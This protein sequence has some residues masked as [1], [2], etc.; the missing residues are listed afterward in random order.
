ML[1]SQAVRY[2]NK[3]IDNFMYSTTSPRAAA[4]DGESGAPPQ[5]AEANDGGRRATG[6][7]QS[8]TSGAG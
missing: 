6:G 1:V 3:S 2:K 8:P 5:P 4:A 7:A